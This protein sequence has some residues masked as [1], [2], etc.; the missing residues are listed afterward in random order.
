MGSVVPE[1]SPHKAELI[2]PCGINCALCK[3]YLRPR[4]HCP[5]CLGDDSQK[6]ITTIRCRIK[7]C[8]EPRPGRRAFCSSCRRFPCRDLLH[9]DTRYR[10]KYGASPVDNLQKIK[11]I[12]LRAFVR[13][14]KSKWVC[15]EC[16][17]AICM[18][19]PQCLKCGGS[20]HGRLDK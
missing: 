4:K 8:M 16:G 14:E 10:K 7:N 6:A 1:M 11:R 15:P 5:G 20:W 3:A 2:A 19:K 12:G 17:A 13:S 9:L 18:H